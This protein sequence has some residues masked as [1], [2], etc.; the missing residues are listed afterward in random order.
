MEVGFDKEIDAI[1]RRARADE[2]VTS[3]G[4]HLDADEISA[5]AENALPE[6]LRQSYTA[7]FADCTRCRKFL[8]NVIL[9]NSEAETETASSAVPAKIA[10]VKTPWYRKLFVFPQLAY[11]MG[12]MVLL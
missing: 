1:L 7:H 4:A 10:E 6:K 5:F 12:A 2:V 8:S 9:L 3:P 11:A